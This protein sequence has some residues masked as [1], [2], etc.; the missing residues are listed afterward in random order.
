[1]IEGL[2]EHRWVVLGSFVIATGAALAGLFA[3]EGNVPVVMFGFFLFIAGYR[4]SQVGTHADDAGLVDELVPQ[5]DGSITLSALVRAVL[6]VIG[7]AGIAFGVTLFSQTVLDPSVSNAV[8][9]GISSIG[10]YMAAH[11]GINGVGLGDSLFGRV[12]EWL[13]GQEADG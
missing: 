7:W 2:F 3:F 4:L 6:L 12:L 8:F 11:V 5:T 13:P 1:M 9:S 10:G